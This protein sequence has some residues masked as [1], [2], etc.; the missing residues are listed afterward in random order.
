MGP[1]SGGCGPNL[2]SPLPAVRAWAGTLTSLV[3]SFPSMRWRGRGWKAEQ[4]AAPATLS[5]SLVLHQPGDG[6]A[7]CPQPGHPRPEQLLSVPRPCPASGSQ[8]CPQG[9]PLP[10]SLEMPSRWDLWPGTRPRTAQPLA[11]PRPHHGNR[12]C[13]DLQCRRPCP[14]GGGGGT[15][16]SQD[17]SAPHPLPLLHPTGPAASGFFHSVVLLGLGLTSPHLS[18]KM[19]Y[20]VSSPAPFPAP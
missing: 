6:L 13:L 9:W 1:R 3:L 14:S 11:R 7:G 17:L 2:P 18:L 4:P 15:R 8:L 5:L 10:S 16:S 12:L 20:S 19:R